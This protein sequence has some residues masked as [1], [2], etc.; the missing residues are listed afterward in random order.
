MIKVI[1]SIFW[2][3]GPGQTGPRV[4][5]YAQNLLSRRELG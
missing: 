5:F 3:L 1:Q 4:F 2:T